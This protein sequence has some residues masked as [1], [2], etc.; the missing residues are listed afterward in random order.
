MSGCDALQEFKDL[1]PGLYM[2]A[3]DDAK[4]YLF[5]G[6]GTVLTGVVLGVVA[7][8]Y[9]DVW[10]SVCTHDTILTESLTMMH[11]VGRTCIK[12]VHP[13]LFFKHVWPTACIIVR[14]SVSMVSCVQTEST[15]LH[16][17]NS[18][19]PAGGKRM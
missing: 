10:D 16:N 19:P 6:G 7:S 4:Y 1:L 17:S 3:L 5:T 18:P 15:A 9:D 12:T 2:D 14:L 11:A 8:R 13:D